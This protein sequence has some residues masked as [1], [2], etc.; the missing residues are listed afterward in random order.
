[1]LHVIFTLAIVLTAT[2][3]IY[4]IVATRNMIRV[5]ISLEVINKAATLLLLMAGVINGQLARA[6]SFIIALIIVEVVITA[7]GAVIVI[8]SHARTGTVSYTSLNKSKKGDQ[9]E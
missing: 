3:G 6:E 1:M 8:A 4:C 5:L 7:V 2:V 9:N